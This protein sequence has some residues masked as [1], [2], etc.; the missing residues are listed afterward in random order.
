MTVTIELKPKT[1]ERL[2]IIAKK[3][4]KTVEAYLEE[5]IEEKT[6]AETDEGK[7]EV[8]AE[9]TN[10]RTDRFH[11]WLDSHKDRGGPFLSDEA[12]RR[13]NMYEDRF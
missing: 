6:N 3:N 13:E 4:G 10:E 7:K 9:S 1:K 11:R 2:A 12:L 8:A 5:F